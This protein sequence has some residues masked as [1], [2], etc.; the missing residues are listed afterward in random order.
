MPDG[1]DED[2][3]AIAGGTAVMLKMRDRLVYPSQFVA[4]VRVG[5]NGVHR[6]RCGPPELQ[7]APPTLTAMLRLVADHRVRQRV[8]IGFA[9]DL[10]VAASVC[11]H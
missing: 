5:G 10:H 3:K 9:R 2:C 6:R 8:S 11:I 7:R 4:L 1:T